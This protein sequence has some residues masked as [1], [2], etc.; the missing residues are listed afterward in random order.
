MG[1]IL[2]F[3]WSKKSHLKTWFQVALISR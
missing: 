3:W 2:L 1:G